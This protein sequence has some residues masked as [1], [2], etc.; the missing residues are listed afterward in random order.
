MSAARDKKVDVKPDK[1]VIK[2]LALGGL[3]GGGG[4]CAVDVK[5]GKVVRIRPF[6]YDW[7][8]KPEQF[9]PWKI[10]RNGKSY[11]PLFKSVPAPF[12]LAY[13]IPPPAHRLGPER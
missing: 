1:T 3:L 8:Y 9:R 11:R 10:T 13:K 2:A 4:E 12:S 6:H 5:D 7:K